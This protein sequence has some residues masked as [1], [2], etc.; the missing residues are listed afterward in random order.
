MLLHAIGFAFRLS[1]VSYGPKS[2]NIT[3]IFILG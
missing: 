1:W 3:F 2:L